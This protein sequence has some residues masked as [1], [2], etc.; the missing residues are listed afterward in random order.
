MHPSI[1]MCLERR[2]AI[3]YLLFDFPEADVVTMGHILPDWNLDQKKLLLKKAYNALP[4]DGA[5]VVYDA[6]IDD[7]RSTNAFGLMMSVNMLI[8]T[9]G[10]FDY[11]GADCVAWMNNDVDRDYASVD[12]A[13]GAQ[14][15]RIIVNVEP[16][17][18]R[19]SARRRP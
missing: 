9:K 11:T 16:S 17:P 8:E 2:Q 10:G 13:G 3:P 6:I 12:A 19:L 7:D 14:A 15:G 4:R 5:V 1:K 18:G